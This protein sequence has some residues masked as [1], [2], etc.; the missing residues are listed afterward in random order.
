MNKKKINVI[1][2]N[3]ITLAKRTNFTPCAIVC[4]HQSASMESAKIAYELNL[5][6]PFFIGNKKLILQEADSLNW[7]ISN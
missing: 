7:D 1:P 6:N 5:I 4:A 3:L 2:K